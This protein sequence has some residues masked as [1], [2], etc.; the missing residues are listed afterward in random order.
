METLRGNVKGK[1]KAE[2]VNGAIRLTALAGQTYAST[3]NG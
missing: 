3:I 1:V 2:N